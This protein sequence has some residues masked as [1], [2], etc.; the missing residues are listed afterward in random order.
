[1]EGWWQGMSFWGSVSYIL[2]KKL[3]EVMSLFKAWN[4]GGGGGGGGGSWK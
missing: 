3:K 4:I 1:M 2:S